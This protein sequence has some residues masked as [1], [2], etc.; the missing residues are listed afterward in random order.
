[1]TICDGCGCETTRYTTRYGA[2]PGSFCPKCFRTVRTAASKDHPMIGMPD[3]LKKT[4]WPPPP[5]GY[6]SCSV[7]E[8]HL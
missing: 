2:S 4:C 8:E 1:M 7:P 3:A 5:D 6:S